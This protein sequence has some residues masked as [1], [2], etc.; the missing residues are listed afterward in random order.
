MKLTA[1]GKYGP[2]PRAKGNTSG[3]LLQ[4]NNQNV[5]IDVGSGVTSNLIS[6]IDV[7]DLS[8]IILSHLHFDH[9]SDIGV[10][11]YALSFSKRQDKIK[12]YLPKTDCAVYNLISKIEIFNIVHVEEN[13]LYNEG[14][15]TFSFYKMKHP[16][17]S[18]GVKFYYD[19]K[20]FAY[21]GDTVF[22][23]SVVELSKNCDLVVADG[24]FLQKDFTPSKP[25]MSVKEACSL[26]KYAKKVLI[27]HINPNYSD[28]EVDKEISSTRFNVEV[29]KENKI[30]EI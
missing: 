11:S 26:Q 29:I 15:L 20:V 4:V 21:T 3:Y 10:L 24:A 30:Y 7:S 2:Y 23:E 13:R 22:N 28:D 14:E 5:L 25:H 19:N 6:K 17:L 27:S 18:Y 1:L 9:V 12:V 16:V 8:F